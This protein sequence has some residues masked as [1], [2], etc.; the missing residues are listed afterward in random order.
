MDLGKRDP[1]GYYVIV[2]KA[3]AKELVGEGL[4]EEVGD[5]V[6]IRIKSKSR[7]QK[8]LRKLQSRGLLC[9]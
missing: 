1:Q 9:T 2:A 6:V 8:L 5:C 3:E 4:I 7:A